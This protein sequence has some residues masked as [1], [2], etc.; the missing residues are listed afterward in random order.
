MPKSRFN[1]IPTIDLTQAAN[2]PYIPGRSSPRGGNRGC[3][4]W[5]T[6]TYGATYS[7]KCCNQDLH[8]QAIGYIGPNP[9]N[10]HAFDIGF[11]QNAFS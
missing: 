3:L 5:G 1:R 2:R 8:A 10:Y 6:S 11:D 4:C 9:A 7:R